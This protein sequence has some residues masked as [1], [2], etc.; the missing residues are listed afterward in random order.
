MGDA[1]EN[2]IA[3]VLDTTETADTGET[4]APAALSDEERIRRIRG[5]P[6]E[7]YTRAVQIRA[8]LESLL[9][10]PK[11]HRMPN[12]ALIGETNNGKT[13]LL[14]K[15]AEKHG[16]PKDPNDDHIVLPVLMI[17]TP[18]EPDEGRLYRSLLERLFATASHRETVDSMLSRLKVLLRHLET[19]MLVLDE[20][21]NAVAGNPVKQRRFL[22]AI[23]YLGNE[24]QV[25][26]VAAGT[27]EALTAIQSDPQLAN[28][29]EPAFLPKWKLDEEYARFLASVEPK[30]MLRKRSN[31]VDPKLAGKLLGFAEGTVGET[32]NILRKLAEHAIKH[33]DEC[34]TK[35]MLDLKLLHS[36]GWV[37]PSKRMQFPK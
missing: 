29:F 3:E 18:T 1:M 36:L 19:R 28:R 11:T 30:L 32:M 35:D 33:Q 27:P 37:E 6:W 25:P 14:K 13:M 5:R 26:I 7:P 22:N 17:Q 10:Y 8:Q 21:N 9:D 20:F 24:L 23:R 16:P 31:L 12:L 15:F 4:A 2:E 34:I